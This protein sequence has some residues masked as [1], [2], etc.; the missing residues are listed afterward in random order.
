MCNIII[1]ISKEEEEAAA[2]IY[3]HRNKFW[4]ILLIQS[5]FHIPFLKPKPKK[6]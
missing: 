3:K 6:L 5:D 4:N 1:I 2:Y